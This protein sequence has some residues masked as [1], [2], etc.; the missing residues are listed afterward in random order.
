MNKAILLPKEQN[1]KFR[2]FQI[3]QNKEKIDP[4][5]REIHLQISG[6]LIK[7]RFLIW[8][9]EKF[10]PYHCNSDNGESE[11]ADSKIIDIENKKKEVKNPKTRKFHHQVFLRL[12]PNL[13][14]KKK[15]KKIGQ[16]D[17]IQEYNNGKKY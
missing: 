10:N 3:L 6:T 2:T 4:I 15:S 13:V 9:S 1:K 17:C 5:L 12:K 16:L 11:I 14:K 8:V 7:V